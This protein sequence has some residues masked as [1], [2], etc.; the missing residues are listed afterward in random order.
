MITIFWQL[1][2]IEKKS[3][4][5]NAKKYLKTMLMTVNFKVINCVNFQLEIK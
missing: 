1:P 3:G 5:S 4:F 2:E